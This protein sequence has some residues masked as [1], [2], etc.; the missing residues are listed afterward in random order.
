MFLIKVVVSAIIIALVSGLARKNPLLAG[1][2][3]AFPITSM[4]SIA[5]LSY[6]KRSELEISKF[7]INVLWGIIPTVLFLGITVLCLKKG[8]TLV[9]S[10]G[11][12]FG[13]WL[14]FT[15]IFQ[16]IEIS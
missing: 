16:R 1:F 4:L 11:I 15:M 5:W 13:L 6:E 7:L 9:F 8:I 10:L 12:G 2:I 3:A 14:V